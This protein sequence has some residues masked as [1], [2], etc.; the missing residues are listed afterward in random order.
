M[1]IIDPIMFHCRNTPTEPALAAPGTTLNIM[2]YGRLERSLNSVCRR[3]LGLGLA[4]GNVVALYVRDR[5]LHAILAL[6]LTRLGIVTISGFNPKLPKTLKVDAVL[7][8]YDY[9]YAIARIVPVDCDWTTG[10]ET[11]IKPEHI[12]WSKP[13]D[14]CRIILTSGSTGEPKA[15]AITHEM[16]A[17]RL[18]RHL[19]MFGNRLPYCSRTYTDLGLPT[20]LGFQVLIGM[21]WRGG[22]LFMPGT[23]DQ[24]TMNAF[25]FYKVQ[26]IISSP[27]GLA[28]LVQA[29]DNRLQSHTRFEM[30]FSGGSALPR[31]LS[32]RVRTR[33]CS[34]LMSAYGSTETS[35]VA[36]A[37]A[38]AIA[39]IGGAVGYVLPGID[40]EIVNSEGDSLPPGTNGT[41]RIRGQ[42]SV[43]GYY[44]D[45]DETSTAF[46]DG[47][48]YPGD[49]GHRSAD[50]L[51]VI[52]GRE[53]ML[54]NLGGDKLQ[55]ELV[56]DVLMAHP[57]VAEAAVFAVPNALG[58]N[59]LWALIVSRGIT[60]NR[61]LQA[62]CSM[63]LPEL[64]VPVKF[65]ATQSLPRNAM[66]KLDRVRLPEVAKLK[67]N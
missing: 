26:N 3:A 30:V 48:F 22:T 16:L 42:F 20:S 23:T 43:A 39:D 45:S 44:N 56:E 66:G 55:P 25:E 40:V 34:N 46:R 53:R 27:G 6:S 62:H 54:I 35:M 1:N 21:L 31:G 5:M 64:F 14:L 12:A 65:I 36:A 67:V 18:A 50:N 17:S 7:T 2:S 32:E 9:P 47:W 33:I 51:L 24:A 37:P 29:F 13:G 38:D 63:K 28:D 59:E 19:Y 11:P 57:N 10:E 49:T 15:V 60:D 52:A 4:R 61:T 58:I 41:V 8:D